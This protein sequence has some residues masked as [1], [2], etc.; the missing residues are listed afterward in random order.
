MTRLTLL[1]AALL[2]WTA[3]GWSKP[4]SPAPTPEKIFHRWL[5]AFNQGSTQQLQA[6][7]TTYKIDRNAQHDA[8]LHA[9]MG[10]FNVLTV[11][12]SSPSKVEVIVQVQ[13]SERALLVTVKLDQTDPI[14]VRLFQIEGVEL[15]AAYRPKRMQIPALAQIAT[16]Q[17]EALAAADSLSGA[18]AVTKDGKPLLQWQG[19]L[20]NRSAVLAVS[21]ETR[22]R[23][24]SLNKMFTAV[25]VLQLVDA[26]KLSLDGTI[27]RY[28]PAYPDQAIAGSI[29]VR[30]LLNHTSGLGEIFGDDFSSYSQTLKTHTDYIKRFGATPPEQVPGRQDGYSNFGYIVLGAIVEAVSG[31]SY[32]DY[33]E[34]HIY[35]V[36]G[37]ASTGSEPESTPVTGRAIAYTKRDGTWQAETASLPWRGMAAGGGYSTVADMLR[38]G[39]ALRTGK[40]L[41]PALLEAATSPQN[42]KHWYGYGFMVSGQG[43]ERQYG[44]EGGAPGANTA[45]VVVPSKG[46]VVVGLSNTDPGAM[47]NVVNYIVR[48]LPL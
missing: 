39:E 18:L 37:M 28:L 7:I 48:R 34:Q 1:A 25:A 44:H 3:T 22:F 9:S 35:R 41:S 14:D 10:D 31:Q 30:Q 21:P 2:L 38:F 47:E 26:G 6:V 17:L 32:Y 8:D 24:A 46:Y 11:K 13:P 23:L 36:A 43:E 12:S 4:V 27:D 19:G 16:Q 29:T 42:H 5:T 40:L 33:V 20:A 15:P 45:F